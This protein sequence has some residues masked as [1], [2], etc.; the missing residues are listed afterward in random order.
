[1]GI[2]PTQSLHRELADLLAESTAHAIV[3][4]Q[5]AFNACVAR[6]GSSDVVLFGAGGLGRRVAQ[7]LRRAGTPPLAFT[8]NDARRWGTELDAIPV[9]SPAE[10]ARRFGASAAFVVTIW[11]AGS[12]HRFEQSRAQL[13]A[14]GCVA[15]SAFPPLLWRV[16]EG[17][18][19]HY[20]QDLPHHVLEQA[21]A[22]TR[23]LELWADEASRREY[24]SQMRFWLLADFDGLSHPVPHPQYFPNDLL[25]LSAGELFVDCGAFTG[26]TL[27]SFLDA[28]HT[29]NR[30]IAL[31]PDPINLSALR[32]SIEELGIAD[33]VAVHAVG[34]G[35][36]HGRAWL[37][38]SGTAASAVRPAEDGG[39]GTPIDIVPLDDLLRDERPTFVKM[40]I[41]GAEPEALAGAR[42]MVR[43]HRPV[44]AVSAYH[45]QDHLW[46]IPLQIAAMTED[47]RFFLRPHNEEGW[48][49][50]CYAIPAERLR[51]GGRPHE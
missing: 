35:R 46:R 19:P 34:A 12:P 47:Y 5:S 39:A 20:C 16:P 37:D 11:G 24:V 49:L 48:D 9:L 50:V 13:E 2:T 38:A 4:E 21:P 45:V 6:I 27:R 32:Q 26:D 43:R 18:L 14:L 23:A 17:T 10:A 30:A 1:M 51:A 44:L 40:D 41:E 8:D 36:E 31:E 7:G 25:D 33:R 28:G 22:A 3:R 15:I 42:E 29:L